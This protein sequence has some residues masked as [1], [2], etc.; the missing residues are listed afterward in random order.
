[1]SIRRTSGGLLSR[2]ALLT[3][4]GC[5]LAADARAQDLALPD[6]SYPD[7]PKQAAGPDGFVPPGWR[8][9]ARAAGDLDRDGLADLALV[10]RQQD[11]KNILA[12]DGLGE[13]PFDTNPRI[14]AVALRNPQEGYRLVVANH[15]L[16]PRRTDPVLA[17]PLEEGGIDIKRGALQVALYRFASAGGWGMGMTTFT[18]R[19]RD[20]RFELIGYDSDTTAR[21]TGEMREIS[22]NYLTGRVK[23]TR[24]HIES[25]ETEVTWRKL[26]RRPLLT[27]DAVGDGLEFDPER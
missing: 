15:A 16:I 19:M 20:G 27:I 26:P 12:N 13:D 6:V 18:F 8:L 22:V 23:V 10:L 4:A 17:D 1:M 9:E 21:N 2:A 7:L 11:P 24:G 3:I 14:L 5:L 25:D